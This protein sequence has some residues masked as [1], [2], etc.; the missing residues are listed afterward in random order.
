M[1]S[2]THRILDANA[3]RAR[4]AMRVMEEFAR[5]VLN[6]GSLSAALKQMRHDL[7]DA[8]MQLESGRAVD[9]DDSGE[10]ARPE[11]GLI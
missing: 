10:H 9:A 7:G 3:N 5:F 6:D 11:S 2:T 1:D 8:V 4:E